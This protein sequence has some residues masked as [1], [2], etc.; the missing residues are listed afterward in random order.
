MVFLDES[1]AMT[2]SS[3]A[4]LRNLLIRSKWKNVSFFLGCNYLSRICAFL[5]TSLQIYSFRITRK[6]DSFVS[7]VR[8]CDLSLSPFTT[9]GLRETVEMCHGDQR[10]ICITIQ[11][12]FYVFAL[13][14]ESSIEKIKKMSD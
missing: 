13:I 5:R 9:A 14:S 8:V 12:S 4:A 2:L 11:E 3:Q 1:D 7:T 6:E 10:K